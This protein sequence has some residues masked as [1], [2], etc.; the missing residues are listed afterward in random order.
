MQLNAEG[1][2][3]DSIG[4]MAVDKP[5]SLLQELG[6]HAS[7]MREVTRVYNAYLADFE[8]LPANVDSQREIL[9][10][11]ALMNNVLWGTHNLCAE[12]VVAPNTMSL[13]G[14]GKYALNYEVTL[15]WDSY[16]NN[17]KEF[18]TKRVM[19]LSDN[20]WQAAAPQGTIV[21]KTN[22]DGVVLQAVLTAGKEN[23]AF[24]WQELVDGV[25]TD[26]P[27]ATADRYAP[28]LHEGEYRCVVKNMGAVI[29]TYHGGKVNTFAETALAPAEVTVGMTETGLQNGELTLV[30]NGR[31]MGEFTF[32]QVKDGW[33][34]QNAAGKYLAVSG[35]SIV[36]KSDAAVWRYENGVFT[37]EITDASAYWKDGYVGFLIG[38]SFSFEEALMREG[39]EVRHIA[40]GRNVP[41]YKVDLFQTVPVGPFRGPTVCSM[42]PMTPENAKKA[43]EITVKMPNVHGAPY[44]MG[45]AEAIGIKDV[46]KPD[47]GEAVDIYPG[48]IPVF[49]PCGV[50]PQ[51][52][53][54]NAKPPIVITHAPGHMF[55]T[56]ILNS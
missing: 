25:W 55:I 44:H 33:T 22:A 5:V 14:T 28:E 17:V 36:W 29:T 26:I 8:D 42:R 13:L 46:M 27:G 47:Y 43:Y 50:T 51:A 21:K 3:N 30:L 56:D 18:V 2:F 7:F 24:Q 37:K 15:N 11:S 53:V 10:A 31:E 32:T 4:V 52:A 38:C 54:E 40:Q 41:M 19:W 49:W 35:K 9:R 23:N 45:P 16:V 6:K 1:W 39:I 12:Y 48:E 20:L 34:I